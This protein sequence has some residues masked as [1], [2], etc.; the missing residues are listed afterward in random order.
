MK[1][2]F[3]VTCV[4]WHVISH[5]QALILTRSFF[6]TNGFKETSFASQWQNRLKMA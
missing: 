5:N 6:K 4:T 1:A 2:T 3:L